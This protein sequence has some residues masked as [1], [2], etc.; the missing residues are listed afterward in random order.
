M[1]KRKDLI[2]WI[3]GFEDQDLSVPTA[4]HFLSPD[5]GIAG[6]SPVMVNSILLNELYNDQTKRPNFRIKGFEDQVLSVFRV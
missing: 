3:K 4:A 2:P 1:I 6:S 5:L